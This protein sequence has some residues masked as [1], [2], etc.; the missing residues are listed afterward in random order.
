MV[1]R[2]EC[3]LTTDDLTFLKHHL[4]QSGHREQVPWWILFAHVALIK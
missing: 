1:H 2:C 4:I 3:G